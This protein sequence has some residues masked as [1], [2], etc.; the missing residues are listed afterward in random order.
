MNVQFLTLLPFGLMLL[1]ALL[2]WVLGKRVPTRT[3]G[4]IAAMAVFASFVSVVAASRTGD[5]PIQFGNRSWISAYGVA[6]QP[7][8]NAMLMLQLDGLSLLFSSILLVGATLGVLYLAQSLGSSLVGYGRLWSS[9]LLMIVGVLLGVLAG[10]ALL[11]SFGW[12][13]ATIGATMTRQIVGHDQ[14]STPSMLS[15]AAISGFAL[16]LALVIWIVRPNDPTNGSFLLSDIGVNVRLIAW[17]PLLLAVGLALGLP[18]FGRI[19]SNDEQTTPALHSLI[20]SCGVP[21]LAIYTFLR[22]FGLNLGAWSPRWLL[23]LQI[24]GS[25]GVIASASFALRSRHFGAIIGWQTAAQWSGIIVVLGNYNSSATLGS[26]AN[27]VILISVLLL[28][29]CTVGSSLIAGF[30]LGW[31]EQRSGSDV[32]DQQPL[33]GQAQRVAGVAYAI[34]AATA[35]GLPPLPGYWARRWMLDQAQPSGWLMLAWSVGGVLLAISYLIPLSL[36]WRSEAQPKRTEP[37][38]PNALVLLSIGGALLALGFFANVLLR[39]SIMPALQVLQPIAIKQNLVTGVSL[40]WRIVFGGFV[41]LVLFLAARSGIHKR[42]PAWTGGERL[43]RDVGTAHAPQALSSVL[44]PLGMV[45]NPLKLGNRIGIA[46]QRTS[47]R[48]AWLMQIF[49]GRFYLTGILVAVAT[50]ILLLL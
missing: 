34:A 43:D 40:A 42:L 35:V 24:W 20:V 6:P 45:A 13:L 26:P 50:V 15:L 41:L 2:C 23:I 8:S 49:S 19:L 48:V 32:L 31:L 17:L 30:A 38:R 33:L 1:I 21:L 18:P 4:V 29:V 37:F 3:L 22:I 39:V 12:G 36:F 5:L 14:K 9:M 47:Q 7:V 28:V 27:L 46:L 44:N 25:L 11:L 10:D 16:L